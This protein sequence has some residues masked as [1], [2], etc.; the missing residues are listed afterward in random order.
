VKSCGCFLIEWAKTVASRSITHGQSY[1]SEFRAFTSAK[2]RCTNKKNQG[3]KNY[4][5]RGIEFRFKSFEEFWQELGKRP[6]GLSVDRINNNGYYEI[7]NVRWATGS[8]QQRNRRDN[9]KT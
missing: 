6:P 5:G 1:T 4:G 8:Q 7:G 2:N 9:A 3:Y